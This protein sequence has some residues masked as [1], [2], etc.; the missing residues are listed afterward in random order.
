MENHSVMEARTKMSQFF[1][2]FLSVSGYRDR[3]LSKFVDFSHPVCSLT[4]FTESR[5]AGFPSL[6]IRTTAAAAR[7]LRASRVR[8]LSPSLCSR[9]TAALTSVF[10]VW[11]FRVLRAEASQGV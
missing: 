9:T 7:L 8:G 3:V 1:L 2:F 11:A 6:C 5:C 10:Q 4:D